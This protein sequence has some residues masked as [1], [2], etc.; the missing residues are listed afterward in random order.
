MAATY[1]S[2]H[3]SG[4][5]YFWL[6][7]QRKRLERVRLLKRQQEILYFLALAGAP[8][9]MGGDGAQGTQGGYLGAPK[10]QA[11]LILPAAVRVPASGLGVRGS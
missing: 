1:Q 4:N 8:V 10:A 5:K 9:G 7:L 6:S 3:W 11:G 2:S